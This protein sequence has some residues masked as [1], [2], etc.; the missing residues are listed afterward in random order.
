MIKN[1]LAAD[2]LIWIASGDT[3]DKVLPIA[4]KTEILKDLIP[5]IHFDQQEV[6]LQIK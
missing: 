4:Y 6:N 1:F 2:I 5:I 3:L